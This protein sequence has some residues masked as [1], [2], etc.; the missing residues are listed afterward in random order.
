MNKETIGGIVCVGT[1]AALIAYA[2]PTIPGNGRI[3][4]WPPYTPPN[5]FK[6][7]IPK[8]IAD[9]IAKGREWEKQKRWLLITERLEIGD[10]AD[11]FF[12]IKSGARKVTDFAKDYESYLKWAGIAW[13]DWNFRRNTVEWGTWKIYHWQPDTKSGWQWQQ[14]AVDEP[15]ITNFET[16][17]IALDIL[18]VPRVIRAFSDALNN[19]SW[20]LYWGSL[21]QYHAAM[22]WLEQQAIKFKITGGK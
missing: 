3:F 19:T 14:H 5:P 22:D 4:P 7:D 9:F 13:G 2:N 1:G 18:Q 21:N 12:G 17:S 10:Y 11:W 20:D 15:V 16:G 8:A 6:I